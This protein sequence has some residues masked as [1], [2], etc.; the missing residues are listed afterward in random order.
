MKIANIA[1]NFFNDLRKFNEIFR[2][3]RVPPS[4]QKIHFST[5]EGYIFQPQRGT[6]FKPQGEGLI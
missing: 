1:E 4:L 2:K 6:F 3:A 5:T